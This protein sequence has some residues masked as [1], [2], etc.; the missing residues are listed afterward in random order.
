MRG[1][2]DDACVRIFGQEATIRQ[3]HA[4]FVTA[5]ACSA[6]VTVSGTASAGDFAPLRS[7]TLE[8]FL[9]EVGFDA[10]QRG[11]VLAA[12]DEYVLRFT[13]AV[14][15]PIVKWQGLDHRATTL[16]DARELQSAARAAAQAIEDAEVPIV[17]A[18]RGAARPGQQV[19]AEEL[20]VRL[21]ISRDLAIARAVDDEAMIVSKG[22]LADLVG[23]RVSIVRIPDYE[24]RVRQYL[25]ERAAVSR[26]LREVV[27][28]IPLRALEAVDRFSGPDRWIH[29]H[30]HQIDVLTKLRELDVRLIEGF[31][32][33]L[34]AAQQIGLLTS[35]WRGLH[36][37]SHGGGPERV[38]WAVR[39]VSGARFKG[40]EC[41]I[42]AV[43]AAFV[44]EWW[45]K[46]RE[47]AVA[48]AL[49]PPNAMD[50]GLIDPKN[51]LST[52][53]AKASESLQKISAR[54]LKAGQ[55][56]RSEGGDAL[57]VEI[58]GLDEWTDVPLEEIDGGTMLE[59]DGIPPGSAARGA[60]W[61]PKPLDFDDLR[62]VY[63]A[64]GVTGPMLDAVGKILEDL[65]T[66]GE[67]LRRE[68]PAIDPA[69]T[70]RSDAARDVVRE[71]L[72][73]LEV[74]RLSDIDGSLVPADGRGIIGWM[75]A[76]RELE[77][78]RAARGAPYL[79][80]PSLDLMAALVAAGMSAE[81]WRAVAATLGGS[82]V[83]MTART[84]AATGAGRVQRDFEL[85]RSFGGETDA[86]GN[87]AYDRALEDVRVR[88]RAR[89]ESEGAT[90]ARLKA[91]LPDDAKQRLQDAWDD[92][93]F[94]RVL[95]D[96]TNMATGLEAA[97]LR[98]N[99]DDVKRRVLALQSR[100]LREWCEMRGAI[101][102]VKSTLA[103]QLSGSGSAAEEAAVRVADSRIGALRFAR[104]ELNRRT[105]RDLR[106]LGVP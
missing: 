64:A 52:A 68:F 92:Q 7:P 43:C 13:A 40:K 93:R 105:G 32:P 54:G 18:I 87:T 26:L 14:E 59:L 76:W 61:L 3:S 56:A 99:S 37:P 21:A 95:A 101:V 94:A 88:E 31:L 10:P 106:A 79:G 97:L 30:A 57:M 22:A 12:H 27:A 67:P 46:A 73:A 41:E 33:H 77:S 103:S 49:R 98:E 102:S 60:S 58:G 44:S 78:A 96:P 83:D 71:R 82:C 45:P 55:A 17:D 104:D 11:V 63:E 16:A 24:V 20:V 86:D 15:G 19:A 2:W 65:N 1:G 34:S 91:L 38:A 89:R 66:E 81:E 80:H 25:D 69:A 62:D 72:L 47:R 75:S 74:S 6:L 42:E 84:R 53:V 85:S 39:A 23:A 29:A 35:W 48:G 9:S 100:W 8:G 90:I 4:R 50:Q 51:A 5:F 70:E 28:E 36:L